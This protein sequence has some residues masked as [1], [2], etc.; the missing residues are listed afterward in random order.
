M[1]RIKT[2]SGKAVVERVNEIGPAG[3]LSDLW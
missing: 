3:G 1:K 2:K